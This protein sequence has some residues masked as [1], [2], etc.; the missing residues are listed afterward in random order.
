VRKVLVVDDEPVI[1]DIICDTLNE[2]GFETTP[3]TS[4]HEARD[5]LRSCTPTFDCIVVDKNLG[6]GGSGWDIARLAR[7]CSEN[8]AVVYV[9]GADARDWAAE[10]VPSS[11]MIQKPFS[12]NQILT[13]VNR[14]LETSH[15]VVSQEKARAPGWGHARVLED[16]F[17]DAPGFLAVAIGEQPRFTFANKAY[18]QLLGNRPLIGRTVEEAIPELNA[19]GI[20]EILSR[21]RRTGEPFTAYGMPITLKNALGSLEQKFI[22]VIY[23]A[24][25][26]ENGSIIG[27]SAQGHDV[28]LQRHT[29][30]RLEELRGT[31]VENSRLKTMDALA[32]AIAHEL[33]QPLTAISN[34]MW[35]AQQLLEGGQD[36]S[37]LAAC[38]QRAGGSANRAGE[39]IRKL[40]RM[41]SKGT[42]ETE[43]FDLR[44]ACQD[45]IDLAL[46]GNS[47][48]RVSYLDHPTYK[49]LGDVVQLQ[50]IIMN[51][52]RNAC[53]ATGEGDGRIEVEASSEG[54]FVEICVRDDGP[55]ITPELLPFIFEPFTTS[56]AEGMGIGLSICKEI[57]EAHGGR[58]TAQ[59]NPAGGAS[60]CFT[61]PSAFRG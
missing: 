46:I 32:S 53:D 3:A 22:D 16:L 13:A 38:L 30:Q 61:V 7:G 11:I 28:T 15:A 2:A 57:V 23:H 40:R 44:K 54:R 33:N 6:A 9:S 45:A 26:D 18:R 37:L 52:I 59:N 41:A 4:F 50:Q 35:T 43:T 42:P 39:I 49:V 8:M 36:P 51:L 10:G 21:V 24:V 47:K 17:E 12:G 19:Q 29:Q 55:G 14:L 58:I 5:V 20:L 48:L 56:K 25:S 31:L 1:V 34:D 60:I 27:L